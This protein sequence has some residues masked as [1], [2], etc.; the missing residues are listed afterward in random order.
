MD[1]EKYPVVSSQGHTVFEFLSEGQKGTIRKVVRYQEITV[2]LFNL[3]FGDWDE[4]RQALSDLVRSNNN[5]RDKVLAT[6]AFIIFEFMEYHP[7]AVVFVKGSTEARTRLYQ[8]GIKNNWLEIS[9]LFSVKGY[10][11]DSWEPFESAKNYDAFYI[12]T[13][14]KI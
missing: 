5:D 1:N 12:S 11:Q 14:E 9:H 13:K 6:V 10:Y 3:A 4:E 7:S 2:N 8:I